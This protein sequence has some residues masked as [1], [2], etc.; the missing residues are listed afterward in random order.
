[1]KSH[2]IL[3]MLAV[4]LAAAGTLVLP[5]AATQSAQTR[6]PETA[7]SAQ[8][9]QTGDYARRELQASPQ[10]KA[11]LTNL[12]AG[13]QSEKL[14]FQ[15]G[16]T[17]ALDRPI[18]QLSGLKLPADLAAMARKQN[19]L[20]DQLIRIDNNARDEHVRLNPRERLPEL[21]L[22]CTAGLPSFDWRRSGKVTPVRDQGGCGSCWDFAT[23]AAYE[24]SYLIRNGGSPDTS[25]QDVLDCNSSGYSCAG[26]WWAFDFVIAKGD[27]TEA[28]YPYTAVKGP[29]KSSTPESFWAVTWGYVKPGGATPLVSEM[30]QA[31]CQYG[32]LA[33]AVRTSTEFH[34]YTGGVFNQHDTRNVNHGV[35]LIGW[36]DAKG[37]WLIKNS[38]GKYWGDACGYGAEKGYMWIAYGGNSI[39]TAAAWVR[40]RNRYYILPREYYRLMPEIKPMPEEAMRPAKPKP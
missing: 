8:I 31:L 32:P 11:L 13:I 9:A 39:G 4:S 24:S 30:K 6:Q 35:L 16:Y 36:D 34:A 18:E 21:A 15:V 37:A 38:W 22:A 25:E 20:A 12:R 2:R 26:G 10:I 28:A 14:T 1:M 5:S 23:M 40:A 33:V 27:A 29:C 17:A 7:Q 19:A 3:L